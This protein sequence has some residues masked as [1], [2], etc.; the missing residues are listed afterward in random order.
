[1]KPQD[2]FIDVGFQ[3][4]LRQWLPTEVTPAKPPFLLVHGLASNARTWDAVAQRLVAAGHEVVAIDQRGHGHSNKPAKGYDF[5]TITQ[6]LYKLLDKLKW[7]KPILVG[8]SW[9]GNVLLELGARFPG[10]ARQLIFVDGGFLD[11]QQ[12]GAWETVATELRPPNLNG[13]LRTQLATWIKQNNPGW[14]DAGVEAT[15][16]N[17]ET[18]PDATVRPWLALE[19]H[20]LILRAMYE[21]DVKILYPQVKEP[22]LICVADDGSE[23]TTSKRTLVQAALS[24]LKHAEVS[25]F[26]GAAHDIHVDRPSELAARFLQFAN[27][28]DASD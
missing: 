27:E 14:S 17:F 6:D 13:Q 8:Q 21:Q 23:W 10:V 22:V 20:M 2:F 7:Q 9:G 18:L 5:V 3:M 24:G 15:L 12:R 1:M 28:Y 4:H 11:L 19:Y 16:H 26:I 25:W